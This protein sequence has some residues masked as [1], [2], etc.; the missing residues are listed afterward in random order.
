ML[1]ERAVSKIPANARSLCRNLLLDLVH[2]HTEWKL[3]QQLYLASDVRAKL[4]S[5]VA[6]FFFWEVRNLLAELIATKLLRLVENA[7]HRSFPS[8]IRILEPHTHHVVYRKLVRELDEIRL[9]CETIREWKQ[10]FTHQPFKLM[11]DPVEMPYLDRALF[12]ESLQLMAALYN[13]I[14]GLFDVKP[15]A[16]FDAEV[17]GGADD[18]INTLTHGYSPFGLDVLRVARD[19]ES[20][21][22]A[23]PT[24][25]KR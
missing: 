11:E 9:L 7:R 19:Q 3:F 20:L 6:P 5:D 10:K 16:R 4:L 12:E 21:S 15:I 25:S 1:S 2:L 22:E 17:L 13:R 8:L 18:L 14:L 24:R 23:R